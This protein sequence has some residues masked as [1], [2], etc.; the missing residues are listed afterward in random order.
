MSLSI[1]LDTGVSALRAAQVDLDTTSHNI[2]NI[3][4]VGYSRQEVEFQAV[5]PAQSKFSSPGVPLQEIGLGVDAGT[6]RRIR[7]GLLDV[8]YRDVRQLDDDYQARSTA[9]KQAEVTL[10]EPSDQGLQAQLTS[11]FNSFRD[12][13]SQPE[14]I[15]A[16]ST[17]VAQG[18]TLAAAF[19]RTSMLLTTQRGDLDT[20]LDVKVSEVNEKAQ[21]VVDLNSQI[22]TAINS[23]NTAND[24]MDRRDLLLDD[25]AGLA[26]ATSQPGDN[27]TVDVLIGGR[28]LVDST[29]TVPDLLATQ[30]DPTNNNLKKIV[31][32]SDNASA[33]ITG[34]EINGIIVARDVHVTGLINNLDQLAQTLITAVN[35]AHSAGYGLD[36]T[37][38]LPFFS[39]SSAATIGV[40]A[41]LQTNPEKLATSDASGEPGNANVAQAIA[42]V[43]N[44]LLMSGGTATIDD[45]Y[46]GM[47]SNLGVASQAAQAQAT[48]ENSLMQ[49]LDTSRQ[50]VMGV[51][52]NDKTTNLMKAQHTYEAA[53]RVITTA[54]GMLDTLINHMLV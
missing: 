12:L 53:A 18:N 8:Q 13:A 38:G 47:V 48:N 28:K 27:G 23:G 20:S 1:S 29:K 34:G 37:T 7:D 19:N 51:N 24:L 22:R 21:E 15:A 3:D 49:H 26:G 43:Q 6:I 2:A 11:F 31:F 41:T 9:L 46:R 45:S 14:S 35:G 30:P 52:L 10:N 50:S 32:S 36:N 5:P 40:N 16:R 25:L 33:G 4:T 54:D 44:Q 39:G 42:G 17:A